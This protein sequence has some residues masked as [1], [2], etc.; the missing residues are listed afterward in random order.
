[1]PTPLRVLIVEDSED[2]AALVLRE[3]TCA[4]LDVESERVEA[5]GP[6]KRALA[7]QAWDIVI[8]DYSMPGFD[9]LRALDVVR[10]AG[11]D[12]A[13]ILVSGTV[14]EEIA[15]EA[16]RRGASDYIMKD[17]LARLA[18]AVKR[19]LEAA[20]E[21]REQRLT[22]Q[23]LD[24]TRRKLEHV[25]SASPAL[26]FGAEVVGDVALQ[27]YFMSP[28]FEQVMG[29]RAEVVF[30]DPTFVPEH[31]H[32]DDADG[33]A[34]A[35]DDVRAQGRAVHEFRL[36]QPDGTFRWIHEELR[37]VLDPTGGPAQVIGSCMDVTVTRRAERA[38]AQ[39]RRRFQHIVENLSDVVA[40]IGEDEGATYVGPSARTVLGHEPADLLGSR[41]LELIHP[42]DRDAVI[43]MMRRGTEADEGDGRHEFRLRR[44]DGSWRFMDAASTDRT[45][46]PAVRGVIVVMRDITERK[47]ID[48]LKDDFVSMI[49]HELRT[50]L[51]VVMGF[52]QLLARPEVS[53]DPE[54]VG[55]AVRKILQRGELMQATVDDLLEV[56]RIR[57]G[58]FALKLAPCDVGELVRECV[59]L[60]QGRPEHGFEIDV[61]ER[62]RLM[63]TCDRARMARA[64]HNLLGNAVKFSPDGGRVLARAASDGDRVSILIEDEGVGIEPDDLERIFD[65][66]AQG[67]MASTRQFGGFGLGLHIA[68][69]IIDAHGGTIGVRSVPGEG[70]AFTIEIPV[71]GPEAGSGESASD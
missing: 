9:G 45:D 53:S 29:W 41:L 47:Q 40:V 58:D 51:T 42:D 12:I 22:R 67:D 16:M 44:A 7:R 68:K 14:G 63:A 43:V 49:S 8:S 48:Q 3:L 1:M 62:E 39:E 59:E 65:C 66:F 34:R 13:F 18:P 64:V 70:S 28:N 15:V 20:A 11:R 2:D 6:M 26:I 57:F 31:V 5:A 4:G 69:L 32:P 55:K 54:Q 17:S 61:P 30:D 24:E 71:Q 37:A 35:L 60:T 10:S 27:P 50:P 25:V 23:R 38:L 56:S 19:E 46:D 33:M 52:A 36:A 21:R